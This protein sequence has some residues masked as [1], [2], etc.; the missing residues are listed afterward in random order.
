MSCHDETEC[1]CLTLFLIE[2]KMGC[3]GCVKCR[4]KRTGPYETRRAL[5]PNFTLKNWVWN[6]VHA[7]PI[8]KSSSC[9]ASTAFDSFSFGDP[10]FC[11][12]FLMSFGVTEE[13]LARQTLVRPSL[14]IIFG[15]TVRMTSKQIFS[16]SGSQSNHRT[17]WSIPV[18]RCW[19]NPTKAG[20]VGIRN[21]SA[22][23]RVRGSV[24]A[25]SWYW[26]GN[27]R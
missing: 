22:S 1:W 24:A 8:F 18:P 12:A 26:L 13:N 3:F 4:R 9:R 21:V 14:R 10:R 7:T 20:D 15:F 23:N 25:L 11:I 6:L 27:S 19:S 16:P 5:D 2:K 17:R